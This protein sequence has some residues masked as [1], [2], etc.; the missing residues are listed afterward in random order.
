LA[1]R[2]YTTAARFFNDAFAA[3]PDLE[4]TE[5]RDAAIM[6]AAQARCGL[7]EDPPRPDATEQGYWRQQALRWLRAELDFQHRQLQSGKLADRYGV[8]N[9][10][11]IWQRRPELAGIR[12]EAELAKLSDEERGEFRKFWSDVTALLKQ[13]DP[14][15][16]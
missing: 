2:R 6:A 5:E 8:Q 15:G 11:R 14:I 12:D 13:A 1:T 10:L 3:K 9:V 16:D 7:G 4:H